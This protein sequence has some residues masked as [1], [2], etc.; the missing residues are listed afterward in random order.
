MIVMIENP[1]FKAQGTHSLD[2]FRNPRPVTR[3]GRRNRR[4][5]EEGRLSGY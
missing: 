1:D 3:T 5:R 4:A 2:Q